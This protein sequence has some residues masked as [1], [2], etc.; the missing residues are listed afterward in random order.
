MCVAVWKTFIGKSCDDTTMEFHG[1]E[2]FRGAENWNIWKFAVKNLL[3]GTK[4]AYEVC[5]G[6]IQKPTPLVATEAADTQAAYQVNLKAWDK[7]D[8]AMSQIIV[9]TLES[10][11]IALLV[12]CESARDMWLKLHSVYEQQRNKLHI[13]FKQNSS[14]SI[15]I[16]SII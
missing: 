1:I 9:K 4:G 12:T 6:E 7:A 8:R 15:R 11:V 2:K 16:R 5:N 10:K 3:R 13:R 14:V